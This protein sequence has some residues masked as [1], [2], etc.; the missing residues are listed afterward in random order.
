MTLGNEQFR[1]LV[2]RRRAAAGPD[3]GFDRSW[4]ADEVHIDFP[5]IPA[6]VD[7]IRA[8]FTGED[9]E[10][11]PLAAEITLTR[12]EACEG[13]TVPLDVPV[14]AACPLCG[15]RGESWMEACRGCAGSGESLFHHRVR[16]SV[17]AGVC[18]GA[19]FSFR[20]TSPLA[21]PTRVEVRVEV[22]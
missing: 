6:A 1:R 22:R 17:P 9:E 10:S 20:L 5:S 13:A 3:K 16:L 7:R 11:E 21:V 4:C 12:R 15:G 8:G 14:R 18:D 19:T 2:E